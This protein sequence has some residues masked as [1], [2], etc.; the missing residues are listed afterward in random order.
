MN[1]FLEYSEKLDKIIPAVIQAQAEFPAIR[2]DGYNPHFKSKFSSLTAVKDATQPVLAKHGLAV[3]QFP[4]TTDDGKPAL[5]TWLVHES[6]QWIKDTTVLSL[7]KIDPQSQGGAITYL[8]RYA[9]TAV[10]G[11]VADDDDDGNAASIVKP[12]T[13]ALPQNNSEMTRL[14]EAARRA[15][16]SKDDVESDL[17]KKYG[18]GLA[19]ASNE[20]LT[21]MA[22]RLLE[23]AVQKE[24]A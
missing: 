22:D 12:Q 10:L 18:H 23:Q 17:L 19:E 8:R 6:G 3:L 20:E 14:V 11:L 5:T 2:K 24:L 7:S 4:S 16:K 15:G 1:S 13:R 21:D 9:W